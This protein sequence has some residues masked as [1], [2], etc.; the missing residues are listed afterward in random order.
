MKYRYEDISPEQFEDLTIAIC[1][2]LLGIAVQGFS[3]GKDGGRDAKF[4]GVAERFPSTAAPWKGTVI[5]QA[6]HT[7]GYNKSFSETDFF[8][9]TAENSIIAEEIPRIKRLRENKNLDHYMLFSNRR[10]SG[11]AE[12]EICR[13]ISNKTNIP[14]EDIRLFGVEQIERFLKEFPNAATKAGID[15]VDAPLI[16]SPD[17]L[18]E[19]IQALA[20]HKGA[21]KAVFDS[22]PTPRVSYATKNIVN[23]MTPDY[24]KAQQKRYLKETA[25]IHAFLAA[26]ENQDLLQLYESIVDEF[27]LK[28]IS[29]RKDYQTFDN[30][31]EY[32]IDLLFNRDMDLKKNKRLTRAMIFYM[33]WNCDIG[34]IENV[35]TN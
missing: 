32:L 2:H 22:P 29:K 30:I 19:V 5:I 13:H 24:A 34:E 33:Y 15:P 28:I 18:A 35:A 27:Q 20:R 3:K 4:V 6:K 1:H 7:N 25:P 8:S 14:E 11:N 16:V 12:S 9:K 17:D 10:L 23:K 31:M 21:V 26:P